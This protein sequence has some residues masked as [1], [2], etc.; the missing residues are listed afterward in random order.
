MNVANKKGHHELKMNYNDGSSIVMDNRPSWNFRIVRQNDRKII[1]LSRP[2]VEQYQH[3]HSILGA[4]N[5][6][7]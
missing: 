1:G 2:V 6:H 4:H 3:E 5:D 7:K